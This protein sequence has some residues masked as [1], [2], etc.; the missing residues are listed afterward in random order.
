MR[1]PWILHAAAVAQAAPPLA[2]LLHRRAPP[3]RPWI[4]VWA[5]LALG[6]D[7]V[8]LWLSH[9]GINNHWMEYWA[10]PLG[11][12]VLLY[13]LSGW[14][15][16]SLLR[17]AYRAAIPVFAVVWAG[18]VLTI[19]HTRDF[20]MVTGP[21]NALVLLAAAVGM[22]IRRLQASEGPWLRADWFWVGLGVALRYGTDSA[23]H[24]FASLYVAEYPVLVVS[25]LKVRAGIDVVA[26]LLIAGGMLCPS[27][28]TPSGGSSWPGS[29]P[30]GSWSGRSASPP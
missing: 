14:L 16:P 11:T 22:L 9:R 23:V 25:V 20:S 18:L 5:L 3:P 6:S 21:L 30:P 7:G 27:A 28:P 26:A 4:I 15:P 10:V 29:S 12:A 19:E 17:T 13:G 24:P 8:S 1:I 2:A